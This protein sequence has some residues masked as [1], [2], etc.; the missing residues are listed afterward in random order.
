[1]KRR[2][3]WTIT[4]LALFASCAS[5]AFLCWECMTLDG[6]T[7]QVGRPGFK[8]LYSTKTADGS[9]YALFDA[10]NNQ[11]AFCSWEHGTHSA[12]TS[13]EDAEGR[14]ILDTKNRRMG[15]LQRQWP[16]GVGPIAVLDGLIIPIKPGVKGRIR[17]VHREADQDDQTVLLDANVSWHDD[18]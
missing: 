13:L 17:L 2:R 11:L 4:T 12:A 1:M 8:L 7:Y 10:G 18:G 5:L 15:H 3:L 14:D 9:Y 16:L 6:W